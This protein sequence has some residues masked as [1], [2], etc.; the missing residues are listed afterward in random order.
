[1]AR[2]TPTPEQRANVTVLCGLGATVEM[3]AGLLNIEPD[4]VKT[5]Y[6]KEL[7]Q[8]PEAVR[9]E[10]MKQLFNAAKTA[11]GAGRVTAAVRLL[12]MLAKDDQIAATAT[13]SG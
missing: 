3:I 7:E 10:A 13:P 6:A 1:M 5:A 8:G 2:H 4:T 12:D 11:D 9:L